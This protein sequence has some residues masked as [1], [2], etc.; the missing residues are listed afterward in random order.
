MVNSVRQQPIPSRRHNANYVPPTAAELDPDDESEIGLPNKDR[1]LVTDAYEAQN[2]QFTA[3]RQIEPDKSPLTPL[4]WLIAFAI[5][6]GAAYF[7]LVKSP[8]TNT[9]SAT[10]T[11]SVQMQPV[12]TAPSADI[13][14]IPTAPESNDGT[15]SSPAGAGAN[16]PPAHTVPKAN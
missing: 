7:Y 4:V 16:T 11:P 10:T 13:G 15:V 6:A 2:S 12:P 9:P 5:I 8:M 14:A 3:P 1:P